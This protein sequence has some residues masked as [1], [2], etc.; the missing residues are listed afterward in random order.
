MAITREQFVRQIGNVCGKV[1]E[2]TVDGKVTDCITLTRI[3]SD[4]TESQT[5]TDEADLAQL[6]MVLWRIQEHLN[7]KHD[8]ESKRMHTEA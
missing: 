7:K 6:G 8:A 1:T 3:E 2:Q 4:G 5:F